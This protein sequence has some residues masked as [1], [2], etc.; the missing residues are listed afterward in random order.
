MPIIPDLGLWPHEAQAPGSGVRS[1][2]ETYFN[3]KSSAMIYCA[4]KHKSGMLQIKSQEAIGG[5]G[6]WE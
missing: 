1:L 4:E 3:G 2:R 5:G 6:K